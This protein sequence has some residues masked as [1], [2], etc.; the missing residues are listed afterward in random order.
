MNPDFDI[1]VVGGGMVGAS[2]GVALAAPGRRIGILEARPYGS[3]GQPSYDDRSTAL[4]LGSR[5]LLERLDVWPALQAEAAPI[6]HIHV[7]DRGRFGAAHID[8]AEQ[9]VR[10]LGYVAPNR[11]IGAALLPR[12][13]QAEGVELLAPARVADLL[14]PQGDDDRV[15]VRLVDAVPAQRLRA[16][17]VIAADGT[18]SPMRERAG[19]PVETRAYGQVALIANVSVSRPRAGWAYER[20]TADGP[21]AM[22]PMGGA[23]YSL[24]WTHREVDAEAALALDDGCFLAALQQHFGWRLGRIEAVG[25]RASYPLGLTRALETSRGRVALAGNALHT[26]H[27][28]AGQGFNL[29]LRDVE[30]LARALEGAADP[31]APGVLARYARMREGDM[32]TVVSLTDAMVRLFSGQRPLPGFLRSL[33]LVAA[34]CLPDLNRLLARQHMGLYGAVAPTR[35]PAGAELGA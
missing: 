9:G 5:H 31:G 16:R 28:V 8:A 29:A 14:Q 11:A 20:F 19:I 6:A 3:P 7:S 35:P 23:R 25:Q 34:D 10:A 27:P 17:L 4:A 30:A 1:L 21:L 33:G 22:L 18:A 13:Q 24:V 2:L 15:E 12:L 32:R 26:L